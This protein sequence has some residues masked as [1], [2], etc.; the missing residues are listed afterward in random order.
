[1]PVAA[2]ARVSTRERAEGSGLDTQKQEI[3]E[4]AQFHDVDRIRLYEDPGVS[5]GT[6]DREGLQRLLSDVEDG[7]IG[8]VVV[9]K[10][11]RLS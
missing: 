6:M 10:A 3:R 4:W 8:A 5:S 1:M 2:C 9:Y 7:D 11:N